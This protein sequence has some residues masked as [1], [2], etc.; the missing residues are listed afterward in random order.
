MQPSIEKIFRFFKLELE[1]GCDN[2]AVVGGLEKILPVWEAQAR[3]EHLPEGAIKLLH[4]RLAE[5]GEASDKREVLLIN[6]W[7]ELANETCLSE[8]EKNALSAVKSSTIARSIPPENEKKDVRKVVGARRTT[9]IHPP[10]PASQSVRLGLSAP[11]TV[12]QGIG[13][14]HAETLARLGLSS[15]EDLLFYFPRRYDDYSQLKPISRLFFNEEVTII[16]TIKSV[17]NRTLR[18]A[19]F[20]LVEAIIGD[21]SG[22]L[23]LT[24]FNQVWIA[25]RLKPGKQIV[26]SGRVEQYLGRLVINNPEWEPLEQEQLHTNRIVPV[27]PLTATVT[28]RWL[29]RIMYQTISYWSPK[30]EDFLPPAIKQNNQLP[31]LSLALQEVHFP[32]SQEHLQQARRRLAFD[33]IF[34]LQLGVLKQKQSWQEMTGK[35]FT[36]DEAWMQEQT[37]RLPYELT[38]AQKKVLVDFRSDLA[39]GSPMN[40]LLQGD[41]GSG[42]TIVAALT[43]AIVISAGSQAAF[44][45][46]TGILAEQ[47]HRNLRQ[48][49]ADSDK[50]SPVL[51]ANQVCLLVGSTPL[52]ERKDILERLASGDIKLVVGTHTLLEEPV[53][54]NDLQ[55]VVIDE[56][57][58][59]GVEQRAI[60]RTKGTNPHLLV[61]TATP[62][63]RS[64]ALTIYGDLD[65]SVMDEFP[66]GRQVIDTFIFFPREREIGYDRIRRQLDQ[67]YQA[68]IIYPLVEQ[69]EN[70]EVKAA[71]EEHTRLS[72]EVFTNYRLGLLHGRMKSEVKDKVMSD[73]RDGNLDI[74]VSTSVVEVGVDIP[75][76]TVILIEGA[77]RFGL[78]QLHQFRGRVGR[79]RAKSSCFLIPESENSADNLRLQAMVETNDGFILAEKDLDQ[80]GPGDF[81]G[82]RQSGF[83]DLRMASLTDVRM[84]EMARRAAQALYAEDPNLTRPENQYLANTMDHFWGNGKGD[85]S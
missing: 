54:F 30:V 42:K 43:A 66:A 75:N 48:L 6:T 58:R 76:A 53:K 34:L 78:S 83:S 15:L 26:V 1:R 2:R 12:I 29:R 56:Q 64:L 25:N 60:L 62:I 14:R 23:R 71:V 37:T 3:L 33:E 80:R 69:G 73:F 17:S 22:D 65:L 10:V 19:R 82:T 49:L 32:S 72:K 20:N 4:A 24:W 31:D 85:I 41:V 70:D 84:I 47:H 38:S 46:P 9:P 59:F 36:V 45:A 16:G 18:N 21:G 27:Y 28:Q 35:I 68:F 51:Q 11:L 57:H 5:Y 81:L 13:S 63:P 79:G 44:M 77:N 39:S 8:T 7:Q 52:S 50:G 40:R 61:M 74:L 55:F 67:G